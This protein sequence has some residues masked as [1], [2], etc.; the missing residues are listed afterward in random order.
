MSGGDDH[1]LKLVAHLKRHGQTIK[2][3]L[4]TDAYRGVLSADIERID[5][6][7]LPFE[8]SLRAIKPILLLF[9][10]WRIAFAWFAIRRLNRSSEFTTIA[11][12]HLFHD[13][14]PMAFQKKRGLLFVYAYHLIK[15]S[16]SQTGFAARISSLLEWASLCAMR[17][18]DTYIITSS[19]V[20]RSQLLSIFP[21]KGE[22]I[23]LT[24]NGVDVDTI[25]RVPPQEK[26]IDVVFCGRLVRH[27]GCRDLL[28]AISLIPSSLVKKTVLIGKGPDLTEITSLSGDLRLKNVQ[29]VANADDHEKFIMMKSAKVLVLPS[30]EEGWGIVVGEALA[31]GIAVI[32]YEIEEIYSI[33]GKSVTWVERGN[34]EMLAKTIQLHLT[35]AGLNAPDSKAW[36]QKLSWQQILDQE[37]TYFDRVS[38]W[39][40]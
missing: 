40:S 33:W 28:Y 20:V 25:K 27:K 4:P 3:I 9:Y 5:V 26:S 2:V 16:R 19:D 7:T 17:G 11:A 22:H 12:S 35:N 14:F 29:I 18:R 10:L 21:K 24:R 37:I 39:N 15:F 8:S 38:L 32:A 36:Q 31:C 6:P 34:I 13:V 30:Y 1:A 23:F